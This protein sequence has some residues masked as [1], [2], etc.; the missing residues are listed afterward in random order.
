MKIVKAVTSNDN[1]F[2]KKYLIE[3]DNDRVF[4]EVVF[5]DFVEDKIIC[6]S[7]QAG[8]AIGCLH[9][10]TTYSPEPF[11]RNLSKEE[12]YEITKMVIEDANH[13]HK[14]DVLDFS[15]IG[16]CSSNWIAVRDACIMLFED[17]WIQRYTF[18]SVAPRKWCESLYDEIKRG[19]VFPEKITIS[20]H[21][22][23]A[24]SRRMIIPHAEDPQLAIQW[25]KLLKEVGCR[26]VLNYVVH[27]K[28]S[29][30]EHIDALA[31][32]IQSNKKWIDT[33][34][35]SPVNPVIFSRISSGMLPNLFTERLKSLLFDDEVS[36]V[37][38][39][40][41]GVKGNMACGQMRA[42]YQNNI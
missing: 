36:V 6:A 34:R 5:I 35:I 13:G 19:E 15:G 2:S 30:S 1:F 33:V 21:G 10:A 12:I 4:V 40:P 25:W 29:S 31:K 28:N 23:D 16:D 9:C 11:I 38:F 24:D 17:H 37:C 3:S 32:L 20:L 41:V 7:A 22:T 8:C 42:F 27:S 18:S 26:I 39:N 14:I